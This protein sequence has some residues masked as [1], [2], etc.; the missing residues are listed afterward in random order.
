MSWYFHFKLK[1]KLLF[2]SSSFDFWAFF[3]K[4][5]ETDYNFYF[6]IQSIIGTINWFQCTRWHRYLPQRQSQV[7]ID[8]DPISPLQ[9]LRTL[10]Q[11]DTLGTRLVHLIH[12]YQIHGLEVDISWHVRG[13]GSCYVCLRKLGC[14]CIWNIIFLTNFLGENFTPNL[15]WSPHL[16]TSAMREAS[17][18]HANLGI[19]ETW[20]FIFSFLGSMTSDL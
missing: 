2:F 19:E 11:G 9:I 16:R 14:S 15:K 18:V 20:Q 13:T 12:G 6:V 8:P 10:Y 4:S 5:S 17:Q 7:N 3:L 1:I